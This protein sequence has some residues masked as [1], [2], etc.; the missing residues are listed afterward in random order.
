MVQSKQEPMSN[1]ERQAAV[2]GFKKGDIVTHETTTV[3]VTGSGDSHELFAG[4]IIEQTDTGNIGEIH[5][6]GDYGRTWHSWKFKKVPGATEYAIKLH[7][8]EQKLEKADTKHLDAID[9]LR[10]VFQKH[11][12][13]LLPDRFVYDKIKRF[14]YGE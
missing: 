5:A 2:N 7:E 10:E 9:L 6:V 3:L 4:V 13:G 1:K 12:S 14:L 8:M 11:E